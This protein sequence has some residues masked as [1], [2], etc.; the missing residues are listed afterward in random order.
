MI[1]ISYAYPVIKSIADI[2]KDLE[3]LYNLLLD[4]NEEL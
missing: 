2:G 1:Y 3:Q 4:N